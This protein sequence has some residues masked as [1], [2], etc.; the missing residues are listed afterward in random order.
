MKTFFQSDTKKG[1]IVET[2]LG[3]VPFLIM[4]ALTMVEKIG[5]AAVFARTRVFYA[6]LCVARMIAK[7]LG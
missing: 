5:D 7:V 6:D 3:L 1:R 4:L 2:I